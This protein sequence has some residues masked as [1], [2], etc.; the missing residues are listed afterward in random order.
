MKGG[1]DMTSSLLRRA[2]R[3]TVAVA[4]VGATM[5]IARPAAAVH[6]CG[7]TILTDLQLSADLGPCPGDGLIV[8]A[9]EITIDLNGYRIFAA[10]G[11][12]DNAGIVLPGRTRVTVENGTVEGFDAGILI[13]GGVHNTV[14]GMTIQDNVNDFLGGPCDL[15][16]GIAV[17]D[18]DSNSIRRN[19]LVG[20]GPY[21]GVSLV[22]DSDGNVVQRND[23]QDHDIV[24]TNCGNSLQDEGIRIE[25]PGADGNEVTQNTVGNSLLSGI[26]LHGYVCAEPDPEPGNTGNV[27]T[28]NRVTGTEGSSVS[29]GI[30]FLQQ[31]P[32]GI[33]C[34][35]T[36]A[37]VQRN[38]SSDNTGWG[39][40][41]AATSFENRIERNLARNN[42][43]EGIR[44]NGPRLALDFE[45]VGPTL[46]DVTAPDLAP[47]AEGS[48]FQVMF[49]SGSGD[50]TAQ[51]VP[52]D[53]AIPDSAPVN[54]NPVDTSTSAC[55]PADFTAAGFQSGDIALIQ[56]GTCTFV[57]KVDNAIAA[58]AS[59]VVMFNEG[60]TGRTSAAFGSVGGVPI[61][62]LSATYALGM[63]LADLA[64]AGDVTAHIVTNT[65]LETV[66]AAPGATDNLVRRNRAE[67]NAGADGYDGN[68][69]P[70]CDN[71][72]WS[73]NHLPTVNQPCVGPGVVV[74]PAAPPGGSDAAPDLGLVERFGRDRPD[75]AP[76]GS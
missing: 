13:V 12:G 10:N 23:V 66:E 35:A 33:V 49:G 68:L 74:A 21:G 39:V 58:G 59:A 76:A 37:T 54:T 32:A 16:D 34:A 28:F 29:A 44:L 67:G 45:S 22:G 42:A 30:N 31:G 20:N 52:I 50:V 18:S 53:L 40:F 4:V 65:T 43:L 71:N 15:G 47:Y 57:S 1:H 69:D 48:D 56:R 19:V 8:G 24:G 72:T 26:G 63:Q 9:D 14:T 2:L 51:V 3:A 11:D 25:G 17:L 27:V 6:L 41:V 64:D 7:T 61:P 38:V 5:M 55:E 62:V 60:Q 70:P 46:F 75:Q 36:Q 73:A